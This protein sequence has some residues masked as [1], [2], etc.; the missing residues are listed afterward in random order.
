MIW[1]SKGNQQLETVM[2]DEIARHLNLPNAQRQIIAKDSWPNIFPAL[3][4]ASVAHTGVVLLH[5]LFFLTPCLV[6]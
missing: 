5:L 1:R 2:F 6:V 4:K 3:S